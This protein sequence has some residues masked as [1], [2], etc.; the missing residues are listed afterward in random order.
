MALQHTGRFLLSRPMNLTCRLRWSLYPQASGSQTHASVFHTELTSPQRS[1]VG[2][3]ITCSPGVRGGAG[4]TDV[5]VR[6]LQA[7]GRHDLQSVVHTECPHSQKHR[8]K[9]C[10]NNI[11]EKNYLGSS[12]IPS[13]TWLF[14][15]HTKVKINSRRLEHFNT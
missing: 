1:G 7:V 9:T 15:F 4:G 2:P 12:V 13:I 11:R 10:N 3:N 5:L 14:H 6:S 8:N